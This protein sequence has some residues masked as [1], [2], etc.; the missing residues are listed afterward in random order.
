MARRI[1]KTDFDYIANYVVKEYTDRKGRRS[2]L[3]AQWNDVDR[4][5]RQEAIPFNQDPRTGR[6]YPNKEWQNFYELP[7]QMLTLELITDDVERLLFPV[8]GKFFDARPDVEIEELHEI[9]E[10]LSEKF[11]IGLVNEFAVSTDAVSNIIEGLH[12]YG[13]THYD[14]VGEVQKMII[15]A[16]K[17]SAYAGRVRKINSETFD[18]DYR[19]TTRSLKQFPALVHYPIRNVYL[20]DSLPTVLHGDSIIGPAHIFAS[21]I[22]AGSL[23]KLLKTGTDG[24]MKAAA[25]DFKETKADDNITLLE[26]EGDF[27]IPRE[28]GSIYLPNCICTVAQIGDVGNKLVRYQEVGSERSWIVGTYFSDN[29]Q[30]DG[31]PTP[32]GTSPLIMSSP[33]QAGGVCA[34]NRSLHAAIYNAEPAVKYDKDEPGFAATGPKLSPGSTI[35]AVADIV[36]IPIGDVSA[37]MQAYTVFKADYSDTSGVSAPRV[38]QQTKSHQTAFAVDQELSRSVLRTVEFVQRFKR[39]AMTTIL[40]LE[41][42]LWRSIIKDLKELRIYVKEYKQFMPVIPAMLP[43][44]VHFEVLGVGQPQEELLEHQ[45]RLNAIQIAGSIEPLVMQT[46]GQPLNWTELRNELLRDAFGDVAKFTQQPATSPAALPIGIAQRS[47]L[48]RSDDSGEGSAISSD[49]NLAAI[50]PG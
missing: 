31:K 27:M 29:S 3:E 9:K 36:P 6:P 24:W 25:T 42:K 28:D 46:G 8:P 20:D 47:P 14:F 19:N 12:S 44:T 30:I 7:W 5:C 45:K 15:D 10:Y 43:D 33:V 1:S 11:S 39:T 4:Q 37:L 23:V 35:P 32:Y 38:G 21:N 40:H 26:M 16:V 22:K 17:Y 48:P 41:Y 2:N 49:P 13:H 34:F 50:V 18:G